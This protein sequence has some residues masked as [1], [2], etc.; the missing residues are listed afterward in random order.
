MNKLFRTGCRIVLLFGFISI[1]AL[2]SG[3]W[4]G[5][6]R[7]VLASVLLVQGDVAYQGTEEDPSTPLT[8]ETNPGPRSVLRTSGTGRADIALVPGALL[9]MSAASELRIEELR[10]A[11]DGNET[12]DGM[13]ERAARVRL[14]RGSIRIVIDRKDESD[15]HF[16]VATGDVTLNANESCVWYVRVADGKTRVTC[17][18]GKAYARIGSSKPTIVEAGYFAEWPAGSVGVAGEDAAAQIDFR[19]ALEAEQRLRQ[20]QHERLNRRPF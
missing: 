6:S 19:A 20:L 12:E 18:R 15:L 5:V 7:E 13:R 11:K 10:V 1:A 17:A 14:N 3:C 2:S 4:R 16:A 9:Q 8:L